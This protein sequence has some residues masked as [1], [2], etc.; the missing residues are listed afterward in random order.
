MSQN[1]DNSTFWV[2]CVGYTQDDEKFFSIGK[3]YEVHR[4]HIVA[5]N[6]FQYSRDINMTTNSD[7]STWYLSRWY[8]FEFVELFVIPEHLDISIDD[9]LLGVAD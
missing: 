5:D 3:E 6:G 2:R 4:G 8:K 9:I 7:P 1:I